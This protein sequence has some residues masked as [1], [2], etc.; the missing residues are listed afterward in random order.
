MTIRINSSVYTCW[1]KLRLPYASGKRNR[2]MCT[3]WAI[4]ERERALPKTE[5]RLFELWQTTTGAETSHQQ[6]LRTK[7]EPAQYSILWRVTPCSWMWMDGGV[8]FFVLFCCNQLPFPVDG[9]CSFPPP[10]PDTFSL[11][12]C[13]LRCAQK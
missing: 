10:N 13:K 2:T 5:K 8:W 11:S 4:R 12:V 9:G 7:E 6:G 3:C 1:W